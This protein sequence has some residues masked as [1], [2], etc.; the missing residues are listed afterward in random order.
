MPTPKDKILSLKIESNTFHL[1]N[2]D[3]LIT[4][5]RKWHNKMILG[6]EIFHLSPNTIITMPLVLLR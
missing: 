2:Q 5:S 1:I 4:A 6:E 3:R